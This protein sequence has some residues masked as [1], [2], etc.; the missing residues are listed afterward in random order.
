MPRSVSLSP[1][2]RFTAG[3]LA[4]LILAAPLAVAGSLV[5]AAEGP[6]LGAPTG[7]ATS[8]LHAQATRPTLQVAVNRDGKSSRLPLPV[9][10]NGTPAV[11]DTV[12]DAATSV[13]RK[14]EARAPAPAV[15]PGST[16]TPKGCLSAIGGLGSSAAT[17]ETTICVAD[18]SM[19]RG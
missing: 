12:R 7:A 17:E 6:D 14:G 18:L 3:L 4:G 19:V 15:K 2:S 1:R 10:G 16:V 5:V 8:D 11:V 13:V 9:T